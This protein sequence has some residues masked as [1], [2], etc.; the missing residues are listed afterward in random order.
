MKMPKLSAIASLQSDNDDI[1][2]RTVVHSP[3]MVEL[4][5][6]NKCETILE[7]S[8]CAARLSF[9]LEQYLPVLSPL[10]VTSVTATHKYFSGGCSIPH[11]FF[12]HLRD[13]L[14]EN[15]PSEEIN[16]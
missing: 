2:I 3:H 5:C 14:M 16:L 12:I 15:V 8:K 6:A 4:Y 10:V 9:L 13:P 7:V 11:K 1:H